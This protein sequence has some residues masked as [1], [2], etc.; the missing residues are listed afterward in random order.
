MAQE[1]TTQEKRKRG[2]PKGSKTQVNPIKKEAKKMLLSGL[3][4]AIININASAMPLEKIIEE[5]LRNDFKGTLKAYSSILP[6]DINLTANGSISS[7]LSLISD[8]IETYKDNVI[9][10]T[11]TKEAGTKLEQIENKTRT[12]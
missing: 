12:K 11:P 6:K 10:I 2:R 3:R 9:D 7:T 1:T 8:K 5:S 4:H